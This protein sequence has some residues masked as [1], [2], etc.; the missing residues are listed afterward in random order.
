MK[1]IN[2]DANMDIKVEESTDFRDNT[3]Y[4]VIIGNI[5]PNWIVKPNDEEYYVF[6][7]E[8]TNGKFIIYARMSGF[9]T[10][11]RVIKRITNFETIT[12][13]FL[14]DIVLKEANNL[15]NIKTRDGSVSKFNSVLIKFNAN[16]SIK[17]FFNGFTELT[18]DEKLSITVPMTNIPKEDQEAFINYAKRYIT[19]GASSMKDGTY[20][21][22]LLKKSKE[23]IIKSINTQ[24]ASMRPSTLDK[25]R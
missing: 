10:A 19:T 21:N 24:Y 11:T 8:F 20:W 25:Y 4:A 15:K 9:D 16:Y 13:Q 14:R 12:E 17:N 3:V 22:K 18:N 1:I 5:S 7:T 6:W 2:E 23:G